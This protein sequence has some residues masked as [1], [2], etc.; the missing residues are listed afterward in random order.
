MRKQTEF[1][2]INVKLE[3]SASFLNSV[4]F[5]FNFHFNGNQKEPLDILDVNERISEKY[6]EFTY[7]ADNIAQKLIEEVL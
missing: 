1:G 3:S 7:N 4:F 2:C 6:S 5:D